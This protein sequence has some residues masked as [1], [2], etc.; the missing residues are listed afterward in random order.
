VGKVGGRAHSRHNKLSGNASPIARNSVNSRNALYGG[1]CDSQ[2]DAEDEDDD[3][4][5]D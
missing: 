3:H 1:N 5:L 2:K 4:Q